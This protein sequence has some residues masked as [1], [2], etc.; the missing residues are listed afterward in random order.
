MVYTLQQVVAQR[1]DLRQINHDR[2]ASVPQISRVTRHNRWTAS[3]C[4]QPIVPQTVHL[5]NA[6]RV[7]TA[8]AKIQK[9]HHLNSEQRYHTD[10]GAYDFVTCPTGGRS[11][12]SA[13]THALAQAA[14]RRTL[15]RPSCYSTPPPPRKREARPAAEMRR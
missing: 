9:P 14:T 11:L 1:Q 15:R 4:K 8:G 10:K 6:V 13:Q 5:K 7:D 12:Q 3:V 2:S